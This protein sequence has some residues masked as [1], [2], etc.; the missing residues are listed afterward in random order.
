MSAGCRDR[1]ITPGPDLGDGVLAAFS[2][3]FD[4]EGRSYRFS[5]REIKRLAAK[6][7]PSLKLN[8]ELY[9][10]IAKAKHGARFDFEPS[11]D[12]AE[13][14]TT[15]QE[16]IFYMH[17]LRE[18]GRPAQ[19]VPPNLGFKKRQAYPA[20]RAA[21]ADYASHKMWPEL[22]GRVDG[23]FGGDSIA[24]LKDRVA[25]LAAVAGHPNWVL[26]TFPNPRRETDAR[27]VL[28]HGAVPV[29]TAVRALASAQTVGEALTPQRMDET[30]SP[31][32][33]E[34]V[35]GGHYSPVGKRVT[36]GSEDDIVGY[37]KKQGVFARLLPGGF[38]CEGTQTEQSVAIFS[39]DA[40]G[41]YG[42]VSVHLS[43]KGDGT[44]R[45]ESTHRTIQLYAGSAALLQV[46]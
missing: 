9:D 42:F 15:P 25:E 22:L 34:L 8:E 17:W 4:C 24:E 16:L 11:L 29:A 31:G 18:R 36:A 12:E 10:A 35:G 14:L 21:L 40:C 6:F 46:Q 28:L 33:M 30:D 1:L 13:T 3:P 43:A 37:N 20:S 2:A 5:E 45:L 26:F 44:F 7:G 23:Q 19:L 39:P 27:R 38:G 41:L 32:M